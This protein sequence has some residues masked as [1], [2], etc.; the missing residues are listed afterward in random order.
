MGPLMARIRTIKPEFW[1]HEALSGLREATHLLAAQLLNYADDEGYFNANPQLIK[2]EC[3]PLRDPS[4]TIHGSIS[5]LSNIGWLRL[6]SG[7]DGRRYGHIINFLKHQVVNRPKPSKIKAISI[8]WDFVTEQSVINH[9]SI[10]DASR[11]EGKGKEEE[12]K[13]YSV[14]NGTVKNGQHSEPNGSG[15]NAPGGFA[16]EEELEA[17]Y[18]RTGKELLGEAKIASDQAGALLGK[19][20]RAGRDVTI[21]AIRRARARQCVGQ[22]LIRYVQGSLKPSGKAN[23]RDETREHTPIG[24]AYGSPEW[25]KQQKE[26]GLL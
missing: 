11:L 15:A 21:A 5:D 23:G 24:P 14:P 25:V 22:E 13:G 20:K 1:T 18:W 16:S 12:G 26:A 4:V 17:S 9:G 7:P 2:A 8:T 3:S 10:S 19:W 6:G